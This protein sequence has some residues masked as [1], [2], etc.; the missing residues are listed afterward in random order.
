MGMKINT[1]IFRNL[2]DAEKAAAYR[3]QPGYSEVYL[4]QGPTEVKLTD[5]TMGWKV[6]TKRYYG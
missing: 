2:E 3:G 6:V 5:G 4:E 1:E